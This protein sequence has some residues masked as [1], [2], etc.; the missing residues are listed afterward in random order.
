[1]YLVVKLLLQNDLKSCF[2]VSS[3]LIVEVNTNV[4]DL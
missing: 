1:M 4:S 2:F 3:G